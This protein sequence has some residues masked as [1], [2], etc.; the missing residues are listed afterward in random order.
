MQYLKI[1]EERPKKRELVNWLRTENRTESF[2]ADWSK[3]GEF[4]RFSEESKKT[5]ERLGK[6]ELYELREVF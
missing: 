2:I 5:I 6:I 3:T 1:K 4:N